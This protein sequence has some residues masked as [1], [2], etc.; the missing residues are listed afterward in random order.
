MEKILF[1][2]PSLSGIGGVERILP[3][4]GAGLVDK[5]YRVSTASFYDD[6]TFVPV[7]SQ[8]HV[9]IGEIATTGFLNKINKI[10]YRCKFILHTIKVEQPDVIIIS[11]HGSSL[12]GLF[13]KAVKLINLPVLIYVHQAL[14]ASDRG[15]MFGTKW[16]YRY[17]SGFICV[18]K[19]VAQEIEV[20]VKSVPTVIAYNPLPSPSEA[21][22][23]VLII[24]RREHPVLITASR[25]E[26]VR[27]IDILIDFCCQYFTTA[28]GELWILGEG[29]LR[30]ELERRVQSANMKSRI[31]FFGSVTNVQEYLKQADVYVSCARAEAFGVALIE[32]LSAGLPLL[33]SDVNYGPREVM[34][35]TAQPKVYPFRTD[36][37]YLISPISQKEK[38]NTHSKSY[39]DFCYAL[40]EMQTNNN[41]FIESNLVGRSNDFTT[42]AAVTSI[43]KLLNEIK[44]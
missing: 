13:L 10:W 14:S 8:T 25:L 17:A 5:G 40:T 41:L 42:S 23:E 6:V 1:I 11:T 21:I 4:V 32:A 9:T 20:H 16:L 44:K 24:E 36:Y 33:C 43:L 2:Q 18:S 35:V 34:K 19:G 12:I 28:A 7:W 29:S 39:S 31:R 37:G 38:V 26:S 30:S 15:Y 3:S 27:G 22:E